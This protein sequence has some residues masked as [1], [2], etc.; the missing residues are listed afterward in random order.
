MFEGSAS[1][2]TKGY[3]SV[4]GDKFPAGYPMQEHRCS[5][6]KLKRTDAA[7]TRD[8]TQ[9]RT[10]SEAEKYNDGF[11]LLDDEKDLRDALGQ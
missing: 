8:Y 4:C 3:C 2:S 6:E 10:P 7:R 1:S 11:A 9:E 5:K